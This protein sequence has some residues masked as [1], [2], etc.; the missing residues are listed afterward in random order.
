MTMANESSGGF[1]YQALALVAP[2]GT[3]NAM[4]DYM[5]GQSAWN[6]MKETAAADGYILHQG[7]KLTPQWFAE[8]EAYDPCQYGSKFGD[9]PVLV[10]R[11]TLDYVVTPKTSL[12]CAKAYKNSHVITVKTDNYH[13]YEMSYPDSAL[14]EELMCAITKHFVAALRAPAQ[15][16]PQR[17]A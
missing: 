5:G 14:K 13:G 10:I 11:N 8:F 2:A 4:I 17:A 6:A 1:D 9:K 15:N 7:L 12:E 3:R 16:R